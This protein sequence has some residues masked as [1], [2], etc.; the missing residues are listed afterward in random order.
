[1][2]KYKALAQYAVELEMEFEADSLEEAQEIARNADGADFQETGS[3][4]W[5]V[6]DLMEINDE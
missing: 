4:D 5:I 1:M 6:Y 2:A 3:G